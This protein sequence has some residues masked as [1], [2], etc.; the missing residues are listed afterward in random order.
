MSGNGAAPPRCRSAGRLTR[1]VTSRLKMAAAPVT[2]PPP[3][4][5]APPRPDRNN[6]ARSS[7]SVHICVQWGRYRAI[8]ARRAVGPGVAGRRG[9]GEHPRR[10]NGSSSARRC[11]R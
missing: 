7:F 9:E 11:A 10:A 2:P 6:V 5:P 8:S 3:A 4:G 1:H